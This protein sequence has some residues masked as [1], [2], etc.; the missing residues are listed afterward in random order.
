M[1]FL[2]HLVLLAVGVF[3]SF[4]LFLGIYRLMSTD[5]PGGA[6]TLNIA[7]KRGELSVFDRIN[8]NGGL[9][10][11]LDYL[12]ARFL[13][14]DAAI[15]ELYMLWGRPQKTNPLQILHYKEICALVIPAFVG[16]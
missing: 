7:A 1:S 9:V 14:Q 16:Y 6:G 10:D 2:G 3:G 11:R 12:L 5:E 4:T 15:E 13:H 8:P